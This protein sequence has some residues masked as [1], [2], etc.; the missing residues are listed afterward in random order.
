MRNKQPKIHDPDLP[1][2]GTY[3]WS[4]HDDGYHASAGLLALLG[5]PSGLTD[6]AAFMCIV[7][8][9]DRGQVRRAFHAALC[10]PDT[11]QHSLSYRIERP[12]GEVRHVLDLSRIVRDDTNRAHEVHGQIVDVTEVGQSS[13]LASSEK[14]ASAA[15]IAGVG[16]IDVNHVTGASTWTREVYELLGLDPNT[17]AS[18]ERFFERLHPEDADHQ[19]QVWADAVARNVSLETEYRI[20]RPNGDIRHVIARARPVAE[21]EGRH[22]RFVG[23]TMDVTEYRAEELRAKENE[24]RLAL[25]QDTTGIGVW[26]VDMRTWRAVWTSGL[27]DLLGVPQ[28]TP[29]SPDLF[30]DHVHP[31]DVGPL[32][33]TFGK[34]IDARSDFEAEFRIIRTDGAVRDVTGRGRVVEEENGRPVR[35]IGVNYDI[36]DRKAAE[37]ALQD[38]Q[39]RQAFLLD[40]GDELRRQR[41]A[42]AAMRAAAMLL[43]EALGAGYVGYAE[44]DEEGRVRTEAEFHAGETIPHFAGHTYDLDGFGL[45]TADTLRAG[46]IASARDIAADD[47]FTPEEREA[48]LAI[49]VRSYIAAP[50][51]VDDRLEAYLFAAQDRAR[52]WSDVERAMLRDTADRTHDTVARARSEAASDA[53]EARYK[54]LFESIDAG[55]CVVEVDLDGADGR[56]DYRVVEANPGFHH[57]TGFPREILGE[58]LREAAPDLEDSWYEIYGAV[59]RTGE[60]ARFEQ[61]S[62]ALGRSFDVYAF[63]ID[64]PDDGRVA[65]LFRDIT[66]RIAQE[67][68]TRTLLKE[69]NHRS[70]NMLALVDVIARR[71]LADGKEGFADRFSQRLSALAANQDVLV[72][73][74]WR[75][76]SLGR[77][78]RSQLGFFE[79]M[80]DHRI[81]LEG[82]PLQIMPAAAEKLGMALHEL[83]TNAAKYGALSGE[84]GTVQVRWQIE[85]GGDVPVFAMDWRETGGP[86]VE[87]PRRS[88]FGSLVAGALLQASLGGT[89]EPEYREDGLH[90]TLRCPLSAITGS[91]AL[92]RSGSATAA[93]REGGST[94]VLVV[95]DDPFLALSVADLLRDAGLTVIG[96]AYSAHEALELLESARPQVALLDVNLGTETSERVAEAVKAMNVPVLCMSGYGASQLPQVFEAVPYLRKPIDADALLR[97]IDATA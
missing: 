81:L 1:W 80:L 93:P 36:T 17:P 54:L 50:V 2:V 92:P 46:C 83:G 22:E 58:W 37:R 59:A 25:A 84:T 73:A 66:D 32:K 33:E 74:D 14:L 7:H 67:E 91:D 95:D 27:Y 48:V 57:Q 4:V 72:D 76:V 24:A 5:G 63:R 94:G 6:R 85:T 61:H 18:P 53:S 26:D 38:S 12:G 68:H 49:G 11:S 69:V 47:G 65:I 13:F 35:M 42:R 75:E 97:A 29:S 55:F 45:K 39:R 60:A 64:A 15:D 71:S 23:V 62:E 56:I 10:D 96:P 9:E 3:V 31:E 44:V 70:K 43:G 86:A 79:D 8:P 89:V 30:F 82:P 28:G 21:P 90:W 16:F 34:A 41:D 87:E 88:G 51:V 19:A 77:L 78:I 52:D 40:L 20:V